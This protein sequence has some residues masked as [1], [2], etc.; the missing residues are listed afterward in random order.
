MLSVNCKLFFFSTIFVNNF[1]NRDILLCWNTYCCLFLKC[2]LLFFIAPL[3]APAIMVRQDAVFS[4]IGQKVV[5]EC[6]SDSHPN[7]FNYWLD[8]SGKKIIQGAQYRQ[9]YS[10]SCA[11]CI[12]EYFVEFV[13]LI[14][15][16]L[17]LCLFTFKGGIYESMTVENVY[18]VFMKL[19]IR[20]KDKSDFGA[21]KCIANNTLG[22]TEHSVSLHRKLIQHKLC[23]K[24]HAYLFTN[25]IFI[26]DRAKSNDARNFVLA[27]QVDS[28][29]ILNNGI[30]PV[31]HVFHHQTNCLWTHIYHFSFQ[32]HG[33]LSIIHR[34]VFWCRQLQYID[35]QVSLR[36]LQFFTI[37]CH[38]CIF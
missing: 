13:H 4:A 37:T 6:I 19:V 3:V 24:Q 20:P 7:S 33:I 12:H 27:N 28:T 14:W 2:L 18:R 17:Y 36:S 35:R 34:V 30:I 29:E 1:Q 23:F 10:Y 38:D 21:Y 32:I 5:L 31:W 25:I 9:F 11:K 15:G 16:Y 26:T 22:Q 8:P